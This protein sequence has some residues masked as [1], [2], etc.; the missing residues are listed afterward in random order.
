MTQSNTTRR[1]VFAGDGTAN[2]LT[3]NMPVY[4]SSDL[5]VTEEIAE[6]DTVM[7][8]GVD[9]TVVVVAGISAT[10]TPLAVIASGTNWFVVRRLPNTQD[11][12]LVSQTTFPAESIETRFDKLTLQVLDLLE[13]VD[14]AVKLPMGTDDVTVGDAIPD[15]TARLSKFFQWDANGN[16]T[17]VD[18]DTTTTLAAS[19]F[20]QFIMAALDADEALALLNI[21]ISTLATRPAAPASGSVHFGTDTFTWTFYDG[22]WNASVAA[23]EINT[24]NLLANGAC[25]VN[26]RAG[27]FD[28]TATYPNVDGNYMLDQI[29]ML[30]DGADII[31]VTQEMSD[32][33]A[34]FASAIKAVVQNT[35]GK[36]GYLLPM[37]QA[38]CAAILGGSE[39]ASL[40][41]Y[42][43][44]T[45]LTTV[46]AALISWNNT[47]AL[48]T[49]DWIS[50]WNAGGS[51]PTAI[52]NWTLEN[53]PANITID[54]N[55]TR[56]TISDIDID[57]A[58]T[59]NVALF[60]WYNE[61]TA[62][63]SDDLFLTG[64]KVN[65]GDTVA[66]FDQ[67]TFASELLEAQR[68]FRK[69]QDYGTE[70]GQNKGENGVIQYFQEAGSS[71]LGSGV[72]VRFPIPMFKIPTVTLE[73]PSDTSARWWNI[74]DAAQSGGAGPANATSLNIGTSGFFANDPKT[75][76]DTVGDKIGIHYRAEA[77]L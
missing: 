21:Y 26:Q 71:A 45:Q 41:F 6:V 55:W 24:D 33:P 76:K 36:F 70:P 10:I 42:A 60:V 46:R 57:T 25:Q 40:S 16:I 43:K 72:D 48:F 75:V 27:P 20:G 38:Q 69:S 59:T 12:D 52:A 62:S 73:S 39:K 23:V 50:A 3:V 51:N 29:V 47:E 7:A 34:G 2:P 14:R 4:D 8:L 37:T 22:S 54:A 66:P 77:I 56:Y 44:S 58:N 18:I 32:V 67:R 65:A 5:L 19:I 15:L 31:D 1:I 11:T 53:T 13:Q 35:G 17:A 49:R 68:F 63:A 74:T 9:Y 61:T 28:S 30:C 64:F